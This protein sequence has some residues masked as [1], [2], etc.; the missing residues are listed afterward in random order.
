MTY[1]P[2]EAL[3][4]QR[5]ARARREMA[6]DFD[7]TLR[8]VIEERTDSI[9][10]EVAAEYADRL[11]QAHE[12][13]QRWRDQACLSHAEWEEQKR[14]RAVANHAAIVGTTKAG[15]GRP[16]GTVRCI[17]RVRVW[18]D[19][20]ADAVS[21]GDHL[22]ADRYKLDDE[23]EPGMKVRTW[24]HQGNMLKLV[25]DYTTKGNAASDIYRAGDPERPGMLNRV[26]RRLGVTIRDAEVEE[27]SRVAVTLGV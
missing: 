26:A 3:F 6:E 9:R 13:A 11:R 1:D 17:Y 21:M 2:I 4:F 19:S 8:A 10:A 14:Q 22:W 24:G 16:K 5:L 27:Q 20:E 18:L 7:L 12:T 15:G 23:P 25:I